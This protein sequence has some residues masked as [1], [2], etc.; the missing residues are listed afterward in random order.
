MLIFTKFQKQ[1]WTFSIASHIANN[2]LAIAKKNKSNN[3]TESNRKNSNIAIGILK[4]GQVDS[5]KIILHFG[6]IT[7][8]LVDCS[9]VEW[10][11]KYG[12]SMIDKLFPNNNS[13]KYPITIYLIIPQW[14]GWP[15]RLHIP[16]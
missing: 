15:Q 13:I 4:N 6:C 14:N 10:I 7:F 5:T 9:L 11:I 2:F 3:F 16:V 8:I 1:Y 12:I